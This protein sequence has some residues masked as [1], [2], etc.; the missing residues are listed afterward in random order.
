ME[1][2]TP[3]NPPAALDEFREVSRDE[4]YKII[5]PLDVTLSILG[6]YPYTTDFKLR[7]GRLVGK[8]VDSYEGEFSGPVFTRYYISCTWR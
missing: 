6:N 1:T 8:A 3:L 2:K 5:M 4:F 7:Y